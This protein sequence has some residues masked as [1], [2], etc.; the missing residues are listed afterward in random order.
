MV[1]DKLRGTESYDI[2]TQKSIKDATDTIAFY[3][4]VASD[5]VSAGYFTGSVVLYNRNKQTLEED[6]E[7]VLT[8]IHKPGFIARKEYTNIENAFY[9]SITGCYQY[10][11]RSYLMKSSNFIHC[12]PLYTKWM[13]DKETNSLKKKGYQ[14]T[15]ALYQGVSAGNVPFY[16]NLHQKILAIH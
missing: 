11:I 2:D 13:G 14:C 9:S 6:I 10:N 3:E 7:K 1:L 15:N 5:N 12:S 8:L 4:N 16:L